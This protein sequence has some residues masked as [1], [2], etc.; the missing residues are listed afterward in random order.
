VKVC[1]EST[2]LTV[3]KQLLQAVVTCAA[4]P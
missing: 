2:S 4:R 3:Q 1:P